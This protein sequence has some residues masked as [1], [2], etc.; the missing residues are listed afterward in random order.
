MGVT[1][2]LLIGLAVLAY[3]LYEAQL[4]Y[5]LRRHGIRVMGIVARHESSSGGG[6]S[7]RL[8]VQFVDEQGQVHEARNR[9][10]ERMTLRI[11]GQAPVVYLP[12]APRT[13][14]IDDGGRSLWRLVLVV[15][16]GCLFTGLSL[17]DM[18]SR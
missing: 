18:V 10:P 17:W 8:V 1:V 7:L 9:E 4:H 3:G 15:G 13:A 14:R 6:P 16:L 11:G 5:R 12:G 2:F